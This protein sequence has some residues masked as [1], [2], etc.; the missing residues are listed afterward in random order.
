MELGIILQWREII[1]IFAIPYKSIERTCRTCTYLL[2]TK[3]RDGVNKVFESV[4]HQQFLNTYL[5]Y[6]CISFMWTGMTNLPP[7]T[8]KASLKIKYRMISAL[9]RLITAFKGKSRSIK[10]N[11]IFTENLQ[12]TRQNGVFTNYRISNTI[13]H[14]LLDTC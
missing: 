7:L 13:S 9:Y 12:F 6:A 8:G 11:V 1:Y 5:H 3:G 14:V 4:L 2:G 10:H